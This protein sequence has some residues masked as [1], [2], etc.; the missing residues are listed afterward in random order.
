MEVAVLRID[1]LDKRDLSVCIHVKERYRRE[2][3]YR[4]LCVFHSTQIYEDEIMK[5]VV[6]R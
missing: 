5:T 6:D 3:L 1:L 2:Q 4:L